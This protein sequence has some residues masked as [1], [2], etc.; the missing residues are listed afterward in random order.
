MDGYPD[1]TFKPNN[2]LTRIQLADYLMMGSETRQYLSFNG[3]NQFTDV[4][5]GSQLFASSV[6]AT[7]SAL[8]DVFQTQ[9]G[10]MLPYSATQF[11]PN[12][13]VYR[14]DVAYSMVQSL[15]F[16][17]S[18]LAHNNDQV[19]V[20]YNGKSVPIDDANQIS[21]NLRGYVQLALNLNLINAY[22]S[23]TQ[24][25]NDLQPTIHAAFKPTQ[26]VLRADYAVIITRTFNQWI[27]GTAKVAINSNIQTLSTS[28]EFSYSLK[29][30]YPN[31]FNP[32]TNINYSV[33]KDGLVSLV[34]YN[35]LGQKV[36]TLVNEFQPA[37]KHNVS[38]NAN[39]LPSGF[40]IYKLASGNY[41][42]IKK[43]MLLK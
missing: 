12:G 8:T 41:S 29:Q 34:I 3:G 31:P 13:A 40:Y 22:F 39:S 27:N 11:F 21:S 43:M 19:S 5:S 14:Q 9:N 7:G 26:K 1:G 6:T 15:G 42:E 32:S 38:F 17:D 25:P 24:G 18:A 36:Q 4:P 30:N 33:E 16:Q 20:Q 23:L 37:G 35:A 10:V 28:K 2:V